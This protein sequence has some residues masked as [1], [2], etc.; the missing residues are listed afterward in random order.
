MNECM[1]DQPQKMKA[2]FAAHETKIEKSRLRK[3]SIVP[4]DIG[5]PNDEWGV[6]TKFNSNNSAWS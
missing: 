2:I 6:A 5:I 1:D 4:I 3:C